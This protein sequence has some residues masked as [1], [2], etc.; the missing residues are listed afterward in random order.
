M[1]AERHFG[2]LRIRNLPAH[3][4][5]VLAAPFVILALTLAAS[6]RG[7]D[8][9]PE[10]PFR[11]EDFSRRIQPLLHRYCLECHGAKKQE[12]EIDLSRFG[13]IDDILAQRE[14]WSKISEMVEFGAMPPD[15]KPQLAQSERDLLVAWVN[16][17]LSLDCSQIR[18][19][20]RVTIRRLNRAEYDNTIRDLTGLVLNLARDFPSDDVG[21][22]FDNIGDVLSLPPLLF[23]KYM[24]AAEEIAGQAIRADAASG[25]KQHLE[26]R[27]L[28]A[29]GSAELSDY[30]V[31]RLVSSGSVSGE[32]TFERDGQYVL[33]AEAGAQQAGD[34]KAK[35]E[36]TLDGRRVNVSDV[37]ASFDRMEFYEFTTRVTAGKHRLAAG[38]INDYYN[39]DATDPKDRDRNLAIR[40]LEVL[41]PVDWRPEDLPE[42]HRR[43]VIATPGEGRS[44]QAAARQV[45]E[46]FATRAFRRP[47]ESDE[48][49]RLA[50]LVDGVMKRGETYERGIQVAVAAVLVSPHF[51]FRIEDDRSRGDS[52]GIR[53]LDD[54]ELAS[55]LSYFLWS[56]MPDEELFELASRGELKKD[57]TL[58]AQVRRMLH[59]PKSAALV[60]NFAGQWL[61]LRTLDEVTPDPDQFPDFDADLKRAMRRETELLF[62][63]VMR[64]DRSIL[65]FLTAD[66]TFVNERLARHYGLSGIRGDEFQRVKLP[67]SQR[68]G[69]LTQA[70]VLTLTS[71]PTRTSAVKRGKWIMENILGT[72]PPDPPPN[73]PA[74]EE[75]AQA[76]PGATLREQLVLH[77]QNPVCASCHIQMDELGFGFENF[78]ALGRWRDQEKGKPID[79]AG[80]LPGGE[81]FNGPIELVGILSQRDKAFAEALAHKMLTY[82]LGRGLEYYDQ[83]AIDKIVQQMEQNEY[84]LS[85]L[86]SGIVLSE[87]FRM[88]R[89]QGENP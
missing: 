1:P 82:A 3:R 59:D 18:E 75:T 46:H 69:L 54:Y 64:E 25:R 73:V 4:I 31:Y 42:S 58:A 2:P 60:E 16:S 37:G 67:A 71:N 65:D 78:D 28:A 24:D 83:C 35:M 50:G 34:E 76:K 49:D 30:G 80:E 55:R 52:S 14:T 29:A 41:G 22:G 70:S 66:F 5:A 7:G 36:F 17:V 61:N 6:T 15:E 32:F 40:S 20:G 48:V 89:T 79:A 81:R 11:P 9:A 87:P 43:I 68:V 62:A 85:S 33:R 12:A 26:R 27:D 38:F 21:E 19:P 44:P 47:V 57:G 74:L 56:S 10:A 51:L 72:P 13:T 23:E 63:T 86:V 39:P 84:R 77:R 8:Q 88:R 45:L 53:E